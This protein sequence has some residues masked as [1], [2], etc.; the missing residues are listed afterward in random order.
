MPLG[1][2]G[3]TQLKE[4]NYAYVEEELSAIVELCQSWDC[5]GIKKGR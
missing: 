3:H 4:K 2:F 5:G 1:Y